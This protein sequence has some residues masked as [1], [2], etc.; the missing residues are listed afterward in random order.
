MK[1]IQDTFLTS[2]YIE[3]INYRGFVIEAK[4]LSI[5]RQEFQ[6]RRLFLAGD[7]EETILTWFDTASIAKKAVDAWLDQ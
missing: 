1:K 2:P 5:N 4:S 3:S 7:K 6:A